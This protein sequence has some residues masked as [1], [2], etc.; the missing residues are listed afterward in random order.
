VETL[1]ERLLNFEKKAIEALKKAETIED[2]LTWEKNHTSASTWKDFFEEI[3][4]ET[5]ETKKEISPKIQET[6]KRLEKEGTEKREKKE[7]EILEAK[8]LNDWIDV[9]KKTPIEKGSLH[10]IS[11]IQK[12]IEDLFTSMG[13]E[14]ADGPEIETEWHN[15]DALNIPEDHPAR[16]MQDTFWIENT[17]NNPKKN[18]VLRTHTSCV[19]IRKMKEQGAPLKIIAP[20]RVYRN[21]ATDMTHDTTFYQVEGLVIDKNISLSHLKGIIDT[22]LEGLFGKKIKTRFR[23]GFFPFVEPG[24]EVDMW[25]EYTDK[26]ENPKARWIEFMG[27]GMVHPNVLRNGNIDPE[28][29]SGFAFGFGLTRLAMKQY[30]IEDIRLL[31][32]PKKNFLSQF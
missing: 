31:F 25:F 15:F 32:T 10:P 4:K 26:N 7:Q 8:L 18:Y 19:Q 9:T 14:I 24:L 29:Y 16:D 21:E 5:E 23:P 22:L 11:R 13:F 20:G 30:K 12:K 17:K 1:T 6:K 28:K 2:I 27:A 3:K